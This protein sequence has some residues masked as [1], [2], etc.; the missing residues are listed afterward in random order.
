[1]Q[2][3][4]KP[5]PPRA[6]RRPVQGAD[7]ESSSPGTGMIGSV[8]DDDPAAEGRE[9]TGRVG[10]AKLRQMK[11]LLSAV[12]LPTLCSIAWAQP[13][14]LDLSFIPDLGYLPQ[15]VYAIAVQ[16]D[17]KVLVGGNIAFP[18]GR[19]RNIARLNPDGS[20]DSSFD[21][22]SGADSTVWAL[23]LQA[24]G[25][26]VIAGEF[27]GVHGVMRARFARLNPD[28][29]VGMSFNPDLYPSFVSSFPT[30]LAAQSDGKL[31]AAGNYHYDSSPPYNRA[32]G[33]L[34]GDGST[35]TDFNLVTS[36]KS[37]G[38]YVS[39]KSIAVQLD[40]KVVFGGDFEYVDDAPHLGIA[41]LN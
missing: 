5:Y 15:Q 29:S 25:K 38:T 34:N 10:N 4:R 22:G 40:G 33:R 21:V 17:A 9:M 39:V 36:A 12:I 20:L 30:C 1:M 16:P 31:L 37:I 19:L 18:N 23:V 35:D 14:S 2:T 13:G 8:G 11:K 7:L 27:T 26:I 3:G 24:D 41:R 28:G 32:V 6:P